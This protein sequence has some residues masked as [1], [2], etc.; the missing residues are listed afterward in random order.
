MIL[1]SAWPKFVPRRSSV[2]TCER[3]CPATL[4]LSLGV[5]VVSSALGAD[6][7]S[8]TKRRFEVHDSVEMSY[9]GTVFSSAPDD[10]DDDGIISPNGRHFIKVTHRGV[11]PQGLTEGTIWLFDTAAIQKAINY[12][13]LDVPKPVPLARMGAAVNG[14]LGVYVLDAGNTISAPQWSEDGRHLAFLGR[15]GRVNRQIFSVDLDS[16]TVDAL[17]PPAQDVLAY[18]RSGNEFVYLAGAD[19]DLQADQAWLSAG[20]G[21]PDMA[22]GTGT[23][24]MSL[25]YPHFRGNASGEPLEVEVWRIHN[26]HAVPVIDN[27]TGAP[28]RISTKY[29]SLLVSLSHDATRAL[30][31]GDDSGADANTDQSRAAA[32]STKLHYLI[33][34]VNTGRGTSLDSVPIARESAGRFRA[35]WAPDDRTVVLTRVMVTGEGG[36]PL[37]QSSCEI[38]LLRLATTEA[39]CVSRPD[40]KGPS[41]FELELPYPDLIRARYKV[42]RQSVYSAKVFRGHGSSW[43]TEKHPPIKTRPAIELSVRENLN[44][45]PVLLATDP[46]T[47]HFRQVFDPN[48]QLAEI[49]LGTVSIYR[50]KDAHGREDTGGL[51]MPADFTRGKRYS[52]VIQT[53]GFN[54]S[55]FFRAGYSDTSNAGRAIAGREMLV[56]QVQE[57]HSQGEGS[58]RDG[59]ELGMDVYLAAIDKLTAEGIVDPT[60]V[61]IAG[62]SYSGWLVATSL[63]R[64][65]NRFAAGEIANSDPVTLTGYYEYVGTP[66]AKADADFY[67]GA[68][69]Y[70]EGLKTWLERVPSLST[71]KITAP[72]LFQPADPW[73]LLGI[74][75]MYAA[76]LDQ[77]KQVELQYMRTGEHN[78]RKPLQVLA[79]QEMIV[80]WFD[81]WLNGHEEK[82]TT[83]AEQ[84]ARWRKLREAQSAIA[85]NHPTSTGKQIAD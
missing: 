10:L 61:G 9:F 75:D 79:H 23:P 42:S 25:L 74:W 80:D 68:R 19:A 33:F 39:R 60:K 53:H 7:P 11:L 56:L 32:A 16:H 3:L 13:K 4:F 29:T 18:A 78:I 77:G 71:D 66:L 49:A 21:I 73:H 48:P 2:S 70:R 27:R 41:I 76:M 36:V 50:W 45:P 34:N 12:S 72:V 82:D 24:L 52:L 30:T 20:P 84:Y 46:S 8:Q 31:I 85:S 83:K 6:T 17:T 28:V 26:D 43:V 65:P 67:V 1:I 35:A 64:A 37:E 69:P 58:W 63:T 44:E 55:K 62:Y 59:V 47:G 5:L 14:G 51:V 40:Q 57:P 15:N 54:S 22:V 81:F 38:A